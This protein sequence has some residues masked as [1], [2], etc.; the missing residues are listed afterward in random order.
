MAKIVVLS[1]QGI[2]AALGRYE[3]LIQ[4]DP[5]VLGLPA[6]VGS[7]AIQVDSA[8]PFA[9]WQKL[10]SSD[11]GWTLIP[12]SAGA[13]ASSATGSWRASAFNVQVDGTADATAALNTLTG[14]T[15]PQTGGPYALIVGPSETIKTASDVTIPATVQIQS[16]G[17]VFKP[18]S[19][20]KVTVNAQPQGAG[21]IFDHSAG[22]V[23]LSGRGMVSN[24]RWWGAD[25][26]GVAGATTAFN[27][28]WGFLAADPVPGDGVPTGTWGGK[29]HFDSGTFLMDG[30]GLAFGAAYGNTIIEGEG[31]ST[32]LQSP[33]GRVIG[34]AIEFEGTI[35]LY[36]GGDF[37]A[38]KLTVRD[39]TFK[40]QGSTDATTF[41]LLDQCE[42]VVLENLYFQDNGIESCRSL[43]GTQIR[44]VNVHNCH[45]KNV[46]RGR[47]AGWMNLGPQ[48]LTMTD[49]TVE[50][51][52]I[53]VETANSFTTIANCRFKDMTQWGV[54][55]Y[56]TWSG[57]LDASFNQ[58]NAYAGTI[59]NCQFISVGDRAV[60]MPDYTGH[61]N[62]SY[63][64]HGP[65][66]LDG[67]LG[68]IQISNN[69]FDRCG[70]AIWGGAD[71]VRSVDC[72]GNVFSGQY[73]NGGGAQGFAVCPMG[74]AWNIRDNTF[75]L[76]Q[77][78]KWS[79]LIGYAYASRNIGR[80]VV[81]NNTIINKC[82][83]T[84]PVFV[85]YQDDVISGTRFVDADGTISG[86]TNH[87]IYQIKDP[88]NTV[89]SELKRDEWAWY[90][91]NHQ[92]CAAFEPSIIP[93][94]S[95]TLPA[96]FSFKPGDVLVNRGNNPAVTWFNKKCVT[97]GTT[98][99]VA[100]TCTAA[101]TSGTKALTVSDDTGLMVYGWISFPA[102]PAI[103]PKKI[104]THN[105][106]ALTLDAN[107]EATV[108]AGTAVQWAVP[109]FVTDRDVNSLI[110]AS[111]AAGDIIY[112]TSAS[113]FGRLGKGSDGQY[114]SLT[115]GVPVWQDAVARYDA[116]NTSTAMTVTY[117][118]VRQEQKITLTAAT[119]AITIAGI[120]SGGYL[121]LDVF[122]DATG[123]RAPTW[124][125]SGMTSLV[126]T[127]GNIA[128]TITPTA[129]TSDRLLFHND[130]VRC[131]GSVVW[132]NL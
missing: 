61:A 53:G 112:A 79:G 85:M 5:S 108:T 100:L 119:P 73:D 98:N 50:S 86:A 76:G 97:G 75:Q 24:P 22:G 104:L 14:T 126:W 28:A 67:N 23:V 8:T 33:T 116:G 2:E 58:V 123:S 52:S 41:L 60:L 43:S 9:Q 68:Q 101:G 89:I 96:T 92:I 56:S 128:P 18:A 111:Q 12:S 125:Q 20:K 130:G 55:L 87:S 105:G 51:S 110:V 122:Q 21:K 39:L 83:D 109:T 103:A 13:G 10:T 120:P 15:M 91:K 25:A 94:I 124:A 47:G 48:S 82:Y 121:V 44:K 11:T 106:T 17:G 63:P 70:Y 32:I 129:S 49:C 1:S 74:G 115:S 95:A 7:L 114:L 19:G 27:A 26:T 69:L 72:F 3:Y 40:G 118:P 34:T 31:P 45:A 57:W 54:M 29:V 64:A 71:L 80:S 127:N 65:A 84:A 102:I 93:V 132:Q 78:I 81:S 117:T 113:A 99:P 30:Y 46:G 4:G 90:D 36:G 6:A 16:T 42:E 38:S 37:T 77:G 35:T 131:I 88:L 107:L 59:T 62:P 66:H